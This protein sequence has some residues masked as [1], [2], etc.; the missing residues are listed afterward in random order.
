M[1]KAKKDWIQGAV[2]HPGALTKKAQKA[3]ESLSEFMAAPHKDAQTN[4]QVALAKFFRRLAKKHKK[5]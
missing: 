3:G 2:K 4:K 5:S 1:A